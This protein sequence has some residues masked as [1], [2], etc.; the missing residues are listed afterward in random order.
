MG[1]FYFMT[2]KQKEVV[3]PD[4]VNN[5]LTVAR[6]AEFYMIDIELACHFISTMRKEA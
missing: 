1:I 2:Q 6:F 4:Y 5:F 3:Y